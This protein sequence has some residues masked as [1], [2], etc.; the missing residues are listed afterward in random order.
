MMVEM[1]PQQQLPH[2][3]SLHLVSDLSMADLSFSKLV[4]FWSTLCR[5]VPVAV[6]CRSH[7]PDIWPVLLL[8][9]GQLSASAP[10]QAALSSTGLGSTI[11][12]EK[13]QSGSNQ[14]G[15]HTH[16]MD[17]AMTW[18]LSRALLG[19]LHGGAALALSSLLGLG[20]WSI[21]T[22]LFSAGVCR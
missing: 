7:H 13:H 1:R 3:G 15:S 18:M 16:W 6:P 10:S 19:N 14:S 11:R 8:M 22:P 17:E 20:S 12:Q 21:S 5:P 9:G 2:H 4:S